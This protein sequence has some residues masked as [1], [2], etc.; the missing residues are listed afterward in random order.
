M[1]T[2]ETDDRGF[3]IF[4]SVRDNYGADVSVKESSDVEGHAWIFINGGEVRDNKGSALFTPTGLRDM[5]LTLLQAAEFVEDKY[6]EKVTSEDA[7]T[8]V[9]EEE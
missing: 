4:G 8:E 2:P 3:A 5:A 6:Y 1:T 7:K 9:S